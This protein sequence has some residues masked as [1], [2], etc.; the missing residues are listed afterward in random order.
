M[1]SHAPEKEVSFPKIISAHIDDAVRQD[2]DGEEDTCRSQKSYPR[3]E[4]SDQ[5]AP[6]QPAKNGSEY[7]PIRRRGQPF[8]VCGRDSIKRYRRRPARST[9]PEL[10]KLAARAFAV[11]PD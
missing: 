2:R 10:R 3:P 1:R 9:P 6:D 11:R 8:W 5:G 7:Q 4:Q